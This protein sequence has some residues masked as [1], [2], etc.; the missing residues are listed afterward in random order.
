MRFSPSR[1]VDEMFSKFEAPNL[2]V[3]LNWIKEQVLKRRKL[4]R[5]LL[6]DVGDEMKYRLEAVNDPGVPLELDT[7]LSD[8][9]GREFKLVRDEGKNQKIDRSLIDS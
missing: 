7:L 3:T 8:V 5:D 1:H 2:Q 9:E 4:D 6:D